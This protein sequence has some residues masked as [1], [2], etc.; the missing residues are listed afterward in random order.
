MTSSPSIPLHPAARPAR[1]YAMALLPLGLAVIAGVHYRA[2][3]MHAI[4][5]NVV[6]NAI[7]LGTAAFG[8]ILM[9]RTIAGIFREWRGFSI[10]AAGPINAEGH[11]EISKLLGARLLRHLDDVRGTHLSLLDQGVVHEEL[12]ELREGLNSRQEFGQYLVGLMIAL[13]LLGTFIGLLE[14]LVSVGELIGSFGNNSGDLDASFRS[15]LGNLQRPLAA[16]GTAFAASMFGLM[17]SLLLG[18]VQIVVR[19]AQ[20]RFIDYAHG[21]ASNVAHISEATI[22]PADGHSSPAWMMATVDS[23]LA[24]QRNLVDQVARLSAEAQRNEERVTNLVQLGALT[25]DLARELSAAGVKQAEVSEA[26][27]PLPAAI[28]ALG[29]ELVNIREVAG[30]GAKNLTAWQGEMDRR[31]ATALRYFARLARQNARDIVKAV[32]TEQAVEHRHIVRRHEALLTAIQ[33]IPVLLRDAAHNEQA[34]KDALRELLTR[35]VQGQEKIAANLEMALDQRV[36]MDA[37]EP[38]DGLEKILG[39]LDSL[40]RE[41][42]RDLRIAVKALSPDTVEV[43]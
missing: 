33:E 27:V 40:E 23:M 6:I 36:A 39:R 7:I 9:M 20:A 12:T 21:V 10:L 29:D 34:N 19:S 4:M 5:T 8:I 22:P 2:F 24:A 32:A 13:G 35:S 25:I 17:G 3:V 14:T 30:S 28:A 26:L 38:G 37:T 43:L 41:I 18:L 31:Q 42:A 11:K 15:L 1:F 16:M